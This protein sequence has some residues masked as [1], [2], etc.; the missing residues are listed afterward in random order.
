M[1]SLSQLEGNFDL[2]W[3]LKMNSLGCV[4]INPYLRVDL[5]IPLKDPA[6]QLAADHGPWRE[7]RKK[8]AKGGRW[9]CLNG[10]LNMGLLPGRMKEA[11]TPSSTHPTSPRHSSKD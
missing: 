9:G 6:H 4:N 11:G 3:I 2:R 1:A 5:S 7:E 8:S 10:K